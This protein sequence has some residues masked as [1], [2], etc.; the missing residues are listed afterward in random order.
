MRSQSVN[1]AQQTIGVTHTI[2]RCQLQASGEI[3]GRRQIFPPSQAIE[4]EMPFILA[5]DF[6]PPDHAF[7]F[8]ME[9]HGW[10][11]QLIA[12]LL[13]AIDIRDV[14]FTGVVCGDIPHLLLDM[15]V[16]HGRA[17]F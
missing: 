11:Y 16:F 10:I 6:D 13:V 4:A 1:F 8:W 9:E 14:E 7:R 17:L 15:D 5:W 3:S 12:P 2:R